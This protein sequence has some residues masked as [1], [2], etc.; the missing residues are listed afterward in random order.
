LSAAVAVATVGCNTELTLNAEALE[1]VPSSAQ[2]GDEVVFE[3]FLTVIP[4][5]TIRLSA[6]V[7][8]STYRMETLTLNVNGPFEWI[9]GDAADLI[10][11]YGTGVHSSEVV[12]LDLEA[13]VSVSTNLATFELVEPVP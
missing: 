6:L 5:R 2:P 1:V 10:A 12:V 13:D 7:D 3:F 4:A 9:M 8:G 11:E